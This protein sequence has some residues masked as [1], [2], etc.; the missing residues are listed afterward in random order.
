VT[1]FEEVPAMIGNASN[2]PAVSSLSQLRPGLSITQSV[3]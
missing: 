2:D 1:G 3:A